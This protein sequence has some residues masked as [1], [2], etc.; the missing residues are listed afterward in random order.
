MFEIGQ[1]HYN[2]VLGD[3]SGDGL[4]GP[5]RC[6]VDAQGVVDGR[7]GG[8]G[9]GRFAHVQG[10]PVGAAE[11]GGDALLTFQ[12]PAKGAPTGVVTGLAQAGADHLHEL[13]GDDGDEQ[14][15]FGSDGFVVIDGTQTEFALQG[16]QDRFDIGQGE[17]VF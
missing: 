1:W 11:G 5:S 17:I 6:V 8:F 2:G 15:A 13:V 10:A 4:A 3:G 9:T 14:M 12:E 7:L 16:A